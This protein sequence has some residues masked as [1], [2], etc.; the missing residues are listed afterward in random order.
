MLHLSGNH[1]LGCV[2]HGEPRL[3]WC[4]GGGRF[5][6]CFFRLAVKIGSLPDPNNLWF[7]SAAVA[8]KLRETLVHR[9]SRGW[10]GGCQCADSSRSAALLW[11]LLS[12]KCDSPEEDA[13]GAVWGLKNG[14]RTSAHTHYK[15]WEFIFAGCRP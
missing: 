15:P 11:A 2:W 6:F 9:G 14:P 7:G 8:K 13:A 12:D 4:R 1:W 5:F 3:V 10:G